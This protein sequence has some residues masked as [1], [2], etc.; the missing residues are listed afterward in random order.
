MWRHGRKEGKAGLP[1]DWQRRRLL[2]APR[3]DGQNTWSVH[4]LVG[5]VFKDEAAQ[6]RSIVGLEHKNVVKIEVSTLCLLRVDNINLQLV[7][8]A[9]HQGGAATLFGLWPSED[10]QLLLLLVSWQVLEGGGR[11]SAHC[12]LLRCN[13][14]RW[15]ESGGWQVCRQNLFRIPGW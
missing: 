14:C 1:A 7:L 15:R 13:P 3:L 10:E 9:S 8:I 5:V 4:G 2:A 6:R 12:R 11:L